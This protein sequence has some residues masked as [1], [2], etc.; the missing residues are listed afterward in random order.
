MSVIL[1]V[2]LAV[3]LIGGAVWDEEP[4]AGGSGGEPGPVAAV[5]FSLDAGIEV[6]S[7]LPGTGRLDAGE[8]AEGMFAA[9]ESALAS[10][11]K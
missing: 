1:P 6:A 8:E 10:L 4:R 7:G 5:G 2:T 11:P 9:G 3:P